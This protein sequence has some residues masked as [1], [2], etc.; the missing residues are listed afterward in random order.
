MVC[1][2]F[3]WLDK[4]IYDDWC[5]PNVCMW[6]RTD[7]WTYKLKITENFELFRKSELYVKKEFFFGCY[8][9][10]RGYSAYVVDVYC[11]IN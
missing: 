10:G 2:F 6:A 11:L 3:F 7:V 4:E 1:F 9:M 8:D 5:I